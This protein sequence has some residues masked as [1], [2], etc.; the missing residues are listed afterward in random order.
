MT[1]TQ[2]AEMNAT[3]VATATGVLL[4]VSFAAFAIAFAR[5]RSDLHAGFDRLEARFDNR[6][7]RLEARFDNL[8]DRLD[9]RFD[10]LEAQFDR[11]DNRFDRLE[12]RPDDLIV[13]PEHAAGSTEPRVSGS[14]D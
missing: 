9:N 14:D 10:R 3:V 12:A 1:Q 6:F 11:L 4:P 8:S 7:D 2:T 5:L 13:A